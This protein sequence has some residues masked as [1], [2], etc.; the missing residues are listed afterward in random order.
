MRE[1]FLGL[2][3]AAV[4]AGCSVPIGMVKKALPDLSNVKVQ[5]EK[6]PLPDKETKKYR[7]L[8]EDPNVEVQLA[9]ATV[10]AQHGD[11]SGS[12][13]LREALKRP[14]ARYR[15]NAFFALSVYPTPENIL[16][17]EEAARAEKEAMAK[18]V[19]HRTLRKTL[20]KLE[21]NNHQKG[22]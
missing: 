3:L 2:F 18:F 17:M 22:G 9:A 11:P 12:E 16:A 1:A 7:E 13:V 6:P 19:M 5:A 8:L 10:L 4:L 21:E 15:L 20:K 14:E